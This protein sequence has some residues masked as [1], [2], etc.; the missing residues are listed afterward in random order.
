VKVRQSKKDDTCQLRP[1]VGLYGAMI[2]IYIHFTYNRTSEHTHVYVA[3]H[4]LKKKK[5]KLKYN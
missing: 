2:R 1:T 3:K 4:I 5:T